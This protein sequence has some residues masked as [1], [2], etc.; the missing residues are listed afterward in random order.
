MFKYFVKCEL[1]KS[2]TSNTYMVS[3]LPVVLARALDSQNKHNT[4]LIQP[5]IYIDLYV[6]VGD[7]ITKW[8]DTLNIFV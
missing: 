6:T 2:C 1:S 7:N 3:D 4:I 5:V 8:E